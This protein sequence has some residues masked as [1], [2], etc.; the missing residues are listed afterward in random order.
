MDTIFALASGAGKAGVAVIRISGP[1][2]LH[3]LKSLHG[4]EP[5]PRY[6]SLQRL[7]DQDGSLLD[8]VLVL[9]F[10]A[11][12]SFTGDD[13]VELHLHGSI[14]IV[15]RTL[16]LLSQVSGCRVAKPGEFTRRALENGRFD[17]S[18]VEG[19]A[20]LIDAETEAQRKQAQR[21]LQ[22]GLSDLV[23]T[24]RSLLIEARAFLEVTIDF[25]DE[26]V[27]VDVSDDVMRNIEMVRDGVRT[28][29]GGFTASS[30]VR[31]GFEVA[32]VG[33]PNVG[34]S[35]LL[36][37]LA[38]REAAITSEIAGTTRDVIEVRMDVEGLPVTFLDTA[39]IRDTDDE[40]EALGVQLARRRAREADMRV[41]LM[42]SADD[43]EPDLFMDGD[44]VK[45]G[46]ADL[47]PDVVNGVSGATGVGVPEL[48]KDVGDRLKSLVSGAGV[49]VNERHVSS[50]RKALDHLDRASE[51]LKLGAEGY[52]LSSEE[53]RLATRSIDHLIGHVDIE[54]IY[55]QI[56]SRFCLGK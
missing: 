11:G 55:D 5:K 53:V 14:S 16:S 27:P 44:L 49:A 40:I 46:K 30:K 8:E 35:T 41:F 9:F 22:G 54:S 6:A 51:I 2:S 10:E 52:D 23:E 18:Q 13:V 43:P 32:I 28:E 48:L 45:V 47:M 34:K 39:G 24:W 29:L 20:D 21:L 50:L 31:E 25:A 33:A 19:L 36:N 4:V 17:L 42:T 37:M 7:K 26:D 15:Q 38:G 1:S 12:A 3:A 56:F